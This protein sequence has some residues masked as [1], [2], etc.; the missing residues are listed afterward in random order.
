M[1][2]TEETFLILGLGELGTA[3]LR[4][5]VER[6]PASQLTVLLRPQTLSAPSAEKKLELDELQAIGVNFVAAD[7]AADSIQTLSTVFAAFDT[8]IGC[9]GFAS[10]TPIQRKVCHAILDAGVSRYV[11]WQFGVDYDLIG[12][13]SAQELFDEQLDV[14]DLLRSQNKTEWVIVSTGMFTSF[15]FEPALG[16]LDLKGGVVRALGSFDTAITVTT[17]D[18]IGMLTAEI[19]LA[20]PRIR[21]TVIYTAGDTSTYG[22]FARIVEDVLGRELKREEWSVAELEHAL[23]HDPKDVMKKYRIVFAKGKGVSWSKDQTFNA[24]RGLPVTGLEQWAR[25]HFK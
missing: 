12:R 1:G 4:S 18:D 21:N 15:L 5:F 16:V 25:E 19:L 20:E 9:T 3:V 14:R 8:V 6:I 22:H 24:Q 17:V 23:A 2:S 7:L 13:G 11:P 10:G